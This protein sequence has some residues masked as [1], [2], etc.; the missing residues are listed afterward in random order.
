M[1]T[2]RQQY[3]KDMGAV[4]R[5]RGTR[6]KLRSYELRAGHLQVLADVERVSVRGDPRRVSALVR[7]GYRRTLAA[8]KVDFRLWIS[9][10][11]GAWQARLEWHEPGVGETVKRDAAGQ[12]DGLIDWLLALDAQNLAPG[13]YRVSDAP[14][15]LFTAWDPR[16]EIGRTP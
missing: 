7:I 5:V 14:L 11:K 9:R 15:H 1:G 8:D 2:P 3:R 13:D 4:V 10:E 16:G 12:F 6:T